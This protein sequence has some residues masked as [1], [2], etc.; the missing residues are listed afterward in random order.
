MFTLIALGGSVD[1][2]YGL[3]ALLFPRI[4]PVVMQIEGNPF[5]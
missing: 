5:Q 4:F 2:A 1:W 3:T